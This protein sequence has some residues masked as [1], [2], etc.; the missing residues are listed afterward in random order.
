MKKSSLGEK[1]RKHDGLMV[2]ELHDG[3]A[4]CNCYL[5]KEI[6]EELVRG[7][8]IAAPAVR[9]YELGKAR[10][11]SKELDDARVELANAYLDYEDMMASG[12]E[13]HRPERFRQ[14]RIRVCVAS[15]ALRR[16]LGREHPLPMPKRKPLQR[17]RKPD[18][19]VQGEYKCR[20]K[21]CGNVQLV[22]G[23]WIGDRWIFGS[24][25]DFCR[26][27]GKG[28]V[29]MTGRALKDGKYY[30]WEELGCR[31]TN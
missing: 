31:R 16:L 21:K 20:R 30:T 26:K 28:T 19:D 14:A 22:L 4:C 5:A 17:R 10:A 7:G 11:L 2:E 9:R 27:C 6:R 18:L 13:K 25:A 8:H 1:Q 23:Q 24:D 3:W 12:L 29:E 15:D